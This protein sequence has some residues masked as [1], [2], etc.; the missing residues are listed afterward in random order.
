MLR[1][2]TA[3]AIAVAAI[4]V[5]PE[6][7]AATAIIIGGNHTTTPNDWHIDGWLGGMFA[8]DYDLKPI[9]YPATAGL[10]NGP[11][12]PTITQSV[13]VGRQSMYDTIMTTDGE[14]IVTGTS[15]GTL[16]MDE[17]LAMLA[18]DPNAPTPDRITFIYTA[19]LQHHGGTSRSAMS[20]LGQGFYIPVVDWIVKRP[21]D[22]QYDTIVVVGE[23]DG[24]A[25]FPDRLWNLVA[26]ANALM[27]PMFPLSLSVHGQTAF[28]DLSIVPPENISTTTNSRGATVTSI[29]V[30][31]K[32]LPL[33][34]PLRDIGVDSRIVDVLDQITR[35]IV[36]AG[37]SRNDRSAAPVGAEVQASGNPAANADEL[38]QQESVADAPTA[39]PNADPV[40]RQESS[41]TAESHVGAVRNGEP[42]RGSVVG[43]SDGS[44]HDESGSRGDSEGSALPGTPHTGGQ[45][46][47]D[48]GGGAASVSTQGTETS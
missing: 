24:W 19:P 20:Y 33:W 26:V 34:Q 37:Y 1:A 17:V 31:T 44:E 15:Q 4:T 28:A 3:A 23:Y 36:D 38:D 5:A 18:A 47:I 7:N 42:R 35:P 45:G 40:M 30:P 21:I 6:G 43:G 11:G 29:L 12:S 2:L 9:T 27:A 41:S 8:V 10:L 48:E 14:I 13:A 22:S 16:V 39:E 46:D 32:N 25:D